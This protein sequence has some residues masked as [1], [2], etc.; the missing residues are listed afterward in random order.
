MPRHANR[1]RTGEN[2]AGQPSLEFTLPPSA[3]AL[4]NPAHRARGA[5]ARVRDERIRRAGEDG[6]RRSGARRRSHG[7]RPRRATDG[8]A[9]PR[10]RAGLAH[11]LAQSGRFRI[12]DD[13]CLAASGGRYRGPDRMAGAAD[14]AGRAAD[15]L[16]LR[17]HGAA[18]SE[19]KVAP[20]QAT[21]GNATLKAR[22]DWLVCRET[23]IPDG[24]DLTLVLPV[25]KSAQP[26]A[27]WAEQISAARAALP[28]PLAGW[29]ATAQGSG[30]MIALKLVAPAGA[31]DP[32]VLQFFPYEENLVEPSGAQRLARDGDNYV[33]TLPVAST[34]VAPPHRARR[35]HLGGRRI[36]RGRARGDPRR[37]ILRHARRRAEARAGGGADAQSRARPRRGTTG[38]RWHWRSSRRSSAASSST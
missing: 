15:E 13:D 20:G 25:A 34:F 19:L 2:A 26:D 38:S 29:K 9:A 35:R 5:R 8:R 6:A 12:A 33:L 24:A 31:P 18:L 37:R 10:D 23:C 3:V 1:R 17:R 14:A 32:G 36:R 16:R 30:R 11:V 27:K 28:Q 21:G 22:A 7:A 4:S